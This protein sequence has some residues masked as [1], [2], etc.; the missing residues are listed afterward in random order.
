MT[1]ADLRRNM[2]RQ[3]LVSGVQQREVADKIAVSE[4]E[5]QA[6]Y[7][8]RKQDFTT[9]ADI[10]LRE[11]LI[12]VPTSNAGV[13][14]AEDEAAREKAE[15]VRSRLVA[16]E[17]FP[18]LA[19][20][21]SEAPSKANGGLIGPFKRTDLAPAL[22]KVVEPLQEG[23]LAPVIRVARGYQILKLESR[24][25][26]TVKSFDDARAEIADRVAQQKH[27]A[28]LLRYLDR[29]REQ[30]IIKWGNDELKKAY[31]QALEK[32]KAAV[33]QAG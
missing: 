9:T 20:E 22:Q 5:T 13:N 28:E 3:M 31:E 21:F 24:T 32:R 11:I 33:G 2:E 23:G 27:R 29:L 10:T 7:A 25:P 18:R 26:E 4:E 1:M 17:P 14:V 12:E 30:A 15:L 19:A 16:G 6:Y 8:S